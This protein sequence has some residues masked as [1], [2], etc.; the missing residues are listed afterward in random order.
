MLS[1]GVS[2]RILPR[3]CDHQTRSQSFS[4]HQ[5]ATK[6]IANRS[7][8]NHTSVSFS[9]RLVLG[10]LATG[11]P[12]TLNDDEA[13]DEEEEEEEELEPAVGPAVAAQRDTNIQSE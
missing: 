12:D 13:D 10:L 6:A 3:V 2:E 8:K 1:G 9:R 5:R 4:Q 11:A 7:S